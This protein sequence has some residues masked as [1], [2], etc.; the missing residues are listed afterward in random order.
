MKGLLSIVLCIIVASLY[1]MGQRAGAVCTDDTASLG[2]ATIQDAEDW[3]V[4]FVN[5][6]RTEPNKALEELGIEGTITL[7][8][9]GDMVCNWYGCFYKESDTFPVA[10]SAVLDGFAEY[11]AEKMAEEGF[12]SYEAPDGST[13]KDL[14]I[15]TGYPSANGTQIISAVLIKDFKDP[16][17]AVHVIMQNLLENGMVD[18]ELQGNAA[19]LLAFQYN[20]IGLA[21]KPA[22]FSMADG[23]VVGA[24]Y[25]VIFLDRP[26]DI[27]RS[28]MVHCGHVYRD[29][30]GDGFFED[31][32]GL[33]GL[34]FY[35]SAGD[36]IA[37][38][39]RDGMFCVEKST[40]EWTWRIDDRYLPGMDLHALS[41]WTNGE[42]RQDIDYDK[43]Y[44]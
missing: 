12:F 6:F 8:R 7:S 31:G 29:L 37:K 1:P 17:Q 32:E 4:D 23:S 33:P 2:N 43:L 13:I 39:Y 22:L 41:F 14:L 20:S 34:L 35:D 40:E 16:C 30:N 18:K 19:Q 9:H 11:W 5:R 25:L 44:Q 42:L 28:S 10:R 27:F 15:H 3:V 24:Y 21:L 26:K 38:T 36:N